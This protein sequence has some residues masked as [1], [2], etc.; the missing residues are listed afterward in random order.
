M[1]LFVKSLLVDRQGLPMF[2]MSSVF[3]E[4]IIES[5]SWIEIT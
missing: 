2:P 5:Q 4:N 3:L 1:F